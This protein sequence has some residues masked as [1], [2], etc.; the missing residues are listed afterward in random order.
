MP[1]GD[2]TGPLGMGPKTGRAAGLCSGNSAPG[3]ANPGPRL[4][5]GRKFQAG[6]KRGFG[7]VR[8]RGFGRGRGFKRGF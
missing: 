3:Y 7:R 5:L 1:K 4:G 8:G 6:R 2:R